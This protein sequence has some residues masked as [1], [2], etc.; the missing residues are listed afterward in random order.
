[1]GE[2]GNWE[3]QDEEDHPAIFPL[4]K[5]ESTYGE[6]RSILK[7]VRDLFERSTRTYQKSARNGRE[8]SEWQEMKEAN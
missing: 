8:L 6:K 2:D 7:Q 4:N 5:E 1:M 3:E